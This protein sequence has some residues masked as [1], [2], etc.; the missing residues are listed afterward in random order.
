MNKE[1][2]LTLDEALDYLNETVKYNK[3]QFEEIAKKNKISDTD[4]EVLFKSS[5][6]EDE[7]SLEYNKKKYKKN[8]GMI[9]KFK[10][11]DEN[12]FI[13]YNFASLEYSTSGLT[14][15]YKYKYDNNAYCASTTI[16]IDY[17]NK[18]IN[19]DQ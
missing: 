14:L 16:S 18:L 2:L 1:E 17:A 6:I 7:K 3:K 10:N 19:Q 4:L 9:Y 11:S 12:I 15:V 13:C 5:G 8:I